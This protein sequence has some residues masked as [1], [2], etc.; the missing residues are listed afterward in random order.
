[1]HVQP[2]TKIDNNPAIAAHAIIFWIRFVMLFSSVLFC[3]SF[4]VVLLPWPAANRKTTGAHAVTRA[5]SVGRGIRPRQLRRPFCVRA[6][7]NSERCHHYQDGRAV[8]SGAR[9]GV[10]QDVEPRLAR[11]S[12]P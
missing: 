11:A 8:V 1:M 5:F 9:P 7:R 2:R 4:F 12:P 10:G 3:L 6:D